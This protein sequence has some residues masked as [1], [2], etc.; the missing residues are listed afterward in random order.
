MKYDHIFFFFFSHFQI[1]LFG[2]PP[3]PVISG[4]SRCGA[5]ADAQPRTGL[6]LFCMM[7]SASVFQ[8]VA[9]CLR[10]SFEI[11]PIISGLCSVRRDGGC[12]RADAALPRG[13]ARR[14]PRPDFT[15]K[16]PAPCV[17]LFCISSAISR[18]CVRNSFDSLK[19][20]RF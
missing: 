1:F 19:T 10:Y 15:R 12:A 17:L 8:W 4:L 7:G 16:N 14:R 3:E 5:M 2:P 11:E 6:S 13:A 18:S 9:L 20:R